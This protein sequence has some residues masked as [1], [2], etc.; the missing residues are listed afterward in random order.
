[1]DRKSG[2]FLAVAFGLLLVVIGLGSGTEEVFFTGAF[3]L[4]VALLW[5]G[6]FPVEESTPI[7]VTL[8][9]ISGLLL[10]AIILTQGPFLASLPSMW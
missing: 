3:I 4:P 7:R 10:A 9:A 8:L 1:M 2:L 6:L 5:G